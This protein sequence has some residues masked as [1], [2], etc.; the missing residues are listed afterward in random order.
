MVLETPGQSLTLNALETLI[1]TS[2][3]K[4]DQTVV[5]DD[6]CLIANR[7][8]LLRPLGE[9]GMGNVYLADDLLLARQVAVKTIRPELSGNEE[10]RSRIKHECRLHAA[11]GVHP[12]IVTLYDTI[13]ENGHI[14][15]IMEY[16]AGETLASRLATTLRSSGMPLN[17]A[18]DVIRQLL[19]ALSCIHD[20]D[21]VHRDIKTSNILLQPQADGR[22]LVKL[23]DFGIARAET[24]CSDLTHLTSLGTQG[25]GTP[26]YMAPERIDPQTFGDICQATDLY[27]VG[28]ILYELL[29]GEPPFKGS[30]TEIFSGHLVQLPA[31]DTL[32][33]ALPVGLAAVLHKALA[34]QPADR[35]QDAASFLDAL[36]M[37][38]VSVD[39]LP[40]PA[41]TQ[42]ATLLATDS[43]GA[44]RAGCDATLL[45]PAIGREKALSPL[46]RKWLYLIAV[47]VVLLTGYLLR[48]RF[49]TEPVAQTVL[50]VAA[51]APVTT[52]APVTGQGSS[53]QTGKLNSSALEAVE[54]V[55]QPKNAASSTST[56]H[57]NGNG[58]AEG[59][60]WQVL[61]KN[62]RKIR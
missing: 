6:C 54:N 57:H 5:A 2:T 61:E 26:M 9:G 34:K 28:I 18:L 43:D 1:D 44:L 17:Q 62:S 12:H 42:E 3:S 27:A 21:I 60:E 29:T 32:P 15:L 30:M 53:E 14:Y 19:Q 8:R 36:A 35:H 47:L 51:S 58:A 56:D 59:Q 31:L 4:H 50:P 33:P 16:F 23:T 39:S 40:V 41:T 7:Y 11:I 20:R 38:D 49:F 55:R 52:T 46:Q 48:S 45:A 10:V 37:I 22:Y 24:E 13:E 25:P